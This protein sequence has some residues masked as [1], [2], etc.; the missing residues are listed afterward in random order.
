M[1]IFLCSSNS[2]NTLFNICY[3]IEFYLK[4]KGGV[5]KKKDPTGTNRR[6]CPVQ[7]LVPF[8]K[9]LFSAECSTA[10]WNLEK[11]KGAVSVNRVDVGPGTKKMQS[12]PTKRTFWIS[13]RDGRGWEEARQSCRWEGVAGAGMVW[14]CRSR[15]PLQNGTFWR[16]SDTSWGSRRGYSDKSFP[17]TNC[18][19]T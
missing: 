1:S 18:H 9:V 4:K 19:F 12:L 5:Q 14:P 10:G 15:S 16:A 8:T 3:S 6:L 2:S 7:K 17:L 11:P 13:K